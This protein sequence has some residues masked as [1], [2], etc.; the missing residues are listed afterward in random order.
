M[1]QYYYV[2]ALFDNGVTMLAEDRC[3]TDF[4]EV[5]AEFTK[6]VNDPTCRHCVFSY[7]DSKEVN[8]TMLEYSRRE[9][10]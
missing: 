10:L 8:H 6:Y 9:D 1:Y 4:S 3:Y 5:V 7:Y 2:D